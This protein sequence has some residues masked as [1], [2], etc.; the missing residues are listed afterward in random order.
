MP[1]SLPKHLF[2]ILFFVLGLAHSTGLTTGAWAGENRFRAAWPATDFSKRA[3]PLEQIIS[4]GPPKDGI[5]AIDHPRF[6]T[7]GTAA[8]WL[9]PREPVI[10]LEINGEARAYPLQ[11]L[12]FHEIVNDQ[13][14]NRPVS[15]TFCPLCNAAIVF[16]GEVGG[17]ATTF[18]TTGLL[19]NSDLVMYDRLTESWWQQFTGKGIVGRHMGTRLERLPSAILAFNKFRELFPHGKVLSRQ[20]GY[21]RQYGRNPYRGYDQIGNNP[22]LLSDPV[23]PRL[24]AMERV[25]GVVTKGCSKVLS[26][27]RPYA[28]ARLQQ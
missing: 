14:E 2:L 17:K 3:I 22:F 4:G 20:T 11:I 1:R 5:P 18:G 13:Y 6:I 21:S 8:Q 27:T 9:D 26:E 23:D 12:M 28:D 24:P 10:S 25:L 19:R 7:Q 16:R 15:V